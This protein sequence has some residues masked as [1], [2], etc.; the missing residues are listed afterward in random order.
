MFMF[1][2]CFIV[3]FLSLFRRARHNVHEQNDTLF[4]DGL[5]IHLYTLLFLI[6]YVTVKIFVYAPFTLRRA[7]RIR[8]IR[9]QEGWL[10]VFFV[11]LHGYYFQEHAQEPNARHASVVHSV[12]VALWRTK[13]QCYFSVRCWKPAL[14]RLVSESTGPCWYNT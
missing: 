8:G 10:A 4:S 5:H 13:N 3:Q 12:N 11:K 14:L 9:R 6:F 7:A 1:C 2:V